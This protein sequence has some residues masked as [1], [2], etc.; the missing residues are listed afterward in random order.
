[1]RISDWSSDVCSAD[2]CGRKPADEIELGF[3][4]NGLVFGQKKERALAG[5]HVETAL[6]QARSQ[7]I[8]LFLVERRQRFVRPRIVHIVR[9]GKLHGRS[10]GENGE[11]MHFAYFGRDGS[12]RAYVPDFPPGDMLRSAERRDGKEWVRKC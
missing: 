3:I 4:G 11:L 12:R 8:A 9:Q 1:M 5:Q 2:L 6:A 10:R 7:Q